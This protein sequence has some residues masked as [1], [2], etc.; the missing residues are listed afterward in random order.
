MYIKEKI[1]AVFE[2]IGL[3]SGRY[4]SKDIA[5]GIFGGENTIA[6][7]MK[8]EAS[9]AKVQAELGVIPQDA[10]DE[11]VRKCDV[12][13]IDEAEY[14]K[15]LEVTGHPIVPLIRCYAAICDGGA[16]EYIHFGTTT[17]DIVDNA[18]MLLLKQAYE[19]VQ[20]K[21]N[22]VYDLTKKLA[23]KYR[24]LVSIGRTNDQQAMPITLGFKMATWADELSRSRDRLQE[25]KDRDFVGTFFGATGTLASLEENGIAIQQALMKEL[26]LNDS[27]IMWFSS[28]DR[29][30][31]ITANLCIL[32][33]TLGRIANEIY[34]AQR[35]EVNEMSEGYKPG[36]VGSS[37]MP[38][39]R[40]PFIAISIVQYARQSRSLMIDSLTSMEATNERDGRVL[41][42]E[43]EYLARIFCLTDAALDKMIDLLE[44]LEVH[45]YAITRNLN[46]TGGLIYA[47]AL[48]MELAKTYGRLESHEIIY[49][50]A[51]ASISTHQEFKELLLSD[52]RV[53][54]VL[55]AEDLDRIMRPEGYIGLAEYFV[56]VVTK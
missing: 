26:G 37:T 19:I 17:Q 44:N 31:E 47:E 3:V 56:D 38:H 14:M 7:Q 11:I 28:R 54:K 55:T 1:M 21:T 42:G 8:V 9:L 12:S 13:L 16:G 45:E 6:T 36:K 4:P 22:R 32:D 53:T 24:S 48:M 18:T 46:I 29:L 25:A 34:N 27:R 50:I 5:Q 15:Q 20:N 39:K 30:S 33:G 43:N 2:G 35:T 40:N 52:D 49:E 10:A 23:L 41:M 51:Q